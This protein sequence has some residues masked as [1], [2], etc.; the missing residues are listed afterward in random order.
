MEQPELSE[1]DDD[2]VKQLIDEGCRRLRALTDL[3]ECITTFFSNNPDKKMD[4]LYEGIFRRCH[5]LDDGVVP[6]ASTFALRELPTMSNTVLDSDTQ[7]QVARDPT[8]SH[9]LSHASTS[10]VTPLHAPAFH[11]VYNQQS[12]VYSLAPGFNPQLRNVQT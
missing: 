12:S 9:M 2:K 11:P 8:L 7:A 1:A 4:R 5:R 6:T 3:L 10:A